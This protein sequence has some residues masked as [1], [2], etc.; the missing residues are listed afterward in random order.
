M[1]QKKFHN[2]GYFYALTS[3]V[4]FGASTPAAKYLLGEI[5]P[6]LLA[7]LLY[8]GSGFGLW[9][10]LIFRSMFLKVPSKEA[11]LDYQDWKWL[12]GSIL[13]GGVLAPVLLMSGLRSINASTG[14]L[15]L[16][17]ESV[18]T[19]IIA[20]N[21]VKEHTNKRLVLGMLLIV[22]GGIVLTLSSRLNLTNLLGVLLIAGACLGWGV[23]NNL[24]RNISRADPLQIVAVKGITAG[25]VNLLLAMFFGVTIPNHLS[26]YVG[27][28]LVGFTGYG[29]SIVCFILG[30]RHIGTGRTSASFSLAPFIGATLSI[31]F[32]GESLSIQLI[33]AGILMGWGIWLHL[34]EQHE[35]EHLHES[36]IHEHKHYHDEHHQHPHLPTDPKGESHS[37]VHEH[38]PLIHSHPH[39]PDIHHRHDH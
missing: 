1:I 12:V 39:Y 10:I 28:A 19:A 3:A 15:L 22:A 29:L 26:V 34:T 5:E 36:L 9:F 21:I 27:G 11:K 4:L 25:C 2:I 38:R 35:H 37:H 13:F 23:D 32:L 18:F 33:I 30:L 16:N 17:L 14:S 20:W 6:W 7:G 24:T 31:L 8:A